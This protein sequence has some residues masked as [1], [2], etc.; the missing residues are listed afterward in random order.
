MP[1]GR[2]GGAYSPR[3]PTQNHHNYRE[4]SVHTGVAFESI[5]TGMLWTKWIKGEYRLCVQNH[6]LGPRKAAL[7]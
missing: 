4:N 2:G 1:I 5:R 7:K 6:T 3:E